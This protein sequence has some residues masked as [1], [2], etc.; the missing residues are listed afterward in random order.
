MELNIK[1]V[2]LVADLGT[3]TG[4]VLDHALSLAR[5]YQAKIHIIYCFDI[6]KFRAESTAELYMS[7]V[8]L[9]DSIEDSL[10][11]EESH[12]R[13]QL[14]SVCHERLVK[15][16]ADQSLIAG[17]DIERKPATQAIFDAAAVYLADLIVIGEQRQSG[18]RSPRLSSTAMKVLNSATVPVFVVKGDAGQT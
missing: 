12:I 1:S 17:I 6:I 14:K 15:L 5:K 13:G 4:Y 2:L 16:R 11:E 3:D 8:E 18:L 7:Q 10:V 9:K